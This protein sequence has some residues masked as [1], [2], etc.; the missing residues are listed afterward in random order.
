M[1][2]WIAAALAVVLVLS[3]TACAEPGKSNSGKGSGGDLFGIKEEK[4]DFAEELFELPEEKPAPGHSFTG[5]GGGAVKAAGLDAFLQLLEEQVVEY[6]YPQ[7]FSYEEAMAGFVELSVEQHQA[8]ALD[9]RGQLTAEHLCQIVMENNARYLGDGKT[10]YKPL[11]EVDVMRFCRI[12]TE[13]IN[14]LLAQ[15]PQI[16]KD[17]VYCN[18]GNLKI[19]ERTGAL[20]F[21]AVEQEMLLHVNRTMGASAKLFGG[22][23]YQVIAH[24][25]VHIMQ[26][27]CFCEG[28]E[29]CQ[30]RC[31]MGWSYASRKQDYSDWIWLEEA[32]AER[33]AS[34]HLNCEPMTYT[35]MIGYVQTLNLAT[36]LQKDVPVNY[37]E[38]LSFQPY[39]E[40][41]FALFGATT[42][43][44][45]QEI[46]QMIYA[47]EII[48]SE[49][50]DV[51][52]CYKELYGQEWNE[53]IR[54]AVNYALKPAVVKTI[55]KQFYGNLAKAI[56]EN[57]VE[58]NDVLFLLNLYES[59]IGSHMRLVARAEAPE[60]K[61]FVAWYQTVRSA[62][63]DCLENVSLEDYAAY[64]ATDGASKCNAAMSW[65]SPEK[66]AFLVEKYENT[67]QEYKVA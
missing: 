51:K 36:V 9:D 2:R 33:L 56:R 24:E 11:K 38:Q 12:L 28:V 44:Q 60:V 34:R 13:T 20:D 55:T 30:R 5:E 66:Q 22:G 41:L 45:K 46:Y 4:P 6:P 32:S 58:K 39:A 52:N 43:Q 49:P 59:A 54:D 65:L 50:V 27:G 31:G 25:A 48:Q 7:L 62:F 35:N 19:L 18:L 14:A 61:E 3:V 26:Y 8:C 29:D 17:R 53:Q 16:D 37:I 21:A 67:F 40:P 42:E 47:L 15:Y 63:F 23:M 57:T 1:K 10:F 64:S